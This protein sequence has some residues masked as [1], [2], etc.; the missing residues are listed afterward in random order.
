MLET[1]KEW[2]ALVAVMASGLGA[3]F[4][5]FLNRGKHKR[6]LAKAQRES[7]AMLYEQLEELKKKVILSVAKEVSQTEE[8]AEKQKIIEGLRLHCPECYD[9][10]MN[11]Y[12]TLNDESEDK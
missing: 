11:K 9:S 10:F 5:F 2:W 3:V 8:I 1:L 7:T 6:N 12:I 4:N